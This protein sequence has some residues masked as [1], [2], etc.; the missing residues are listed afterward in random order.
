MMTLLTVFQNIANPY[1]S[2][3][4]KAIFSNV[5]EIPHVYVD[6]HCLLTPVSGDRNQHDPGQQLVHQPPPPLPRAAR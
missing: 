4:Q 5:S 1:P 2:E 6:V 3:E